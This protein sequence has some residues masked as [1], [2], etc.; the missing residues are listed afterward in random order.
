MGGHCRLF[1]G[2]DGHGNFSLYG[3]KN[4]SDYT[5]FWYV[6]ETVVSTTLMALHCDGPLW[7]ACTVSA[8]TYKV[9]TYDHVTDIPTLVEDVQPSEILMT[10]VFTVP[11]LPN[12]IHYYKVPPA[13]SAFG[14]VDGFVQKVLQSR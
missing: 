8:E 9:A 3:T 1:D 5:A 10:A 11:Q 13:P 14:M 12:D 6:S 7:S 2:N 4:R